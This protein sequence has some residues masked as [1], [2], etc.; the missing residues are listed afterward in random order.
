MTTEG[1]T[2][3]WVLKV[4]AALG[5]AT[6]L[7][8]AESAPDVEPT[9]PLSP[10]AS[11]VEPE[12][13]AVA[14]VPRPLEVPP[15]RSGSAMVRTPDSRALLIADEDHRVLRRV[16]LPLDAHAEVLTVALPGAPAS[17]LSLGRL[18][19]V[20]VRDPGLLLI[21]REE[22]NGLVEEA[23]I[24]LSADAWGL[25]VTADLKTALVT[26]AWTHQ[27]S[28]I[29]LEQR[30]LR[31]SVNVAREPRGIAI[32]N[33]G[34]AYVSHLVGSRLT[35]VDGLT[36]A[37]P[38]IKRVELPAA[39]MRAAYG[40]ALHASLGYA[41]VLNADESR[42]FAA[43]HAL[44]G[45]SS[46]WW[47]GAATVDAL[48]TAND[49][50]VSPAHQ[51][52]SLGNSTDMQSLLDIQGSVPLD[53]SAFVQPRAMAFRKTTNTILVVSEGKNELVELDARAVDPSLARTNLYPLASYEPSN[54]P[55]T[56]LPLTGGAP[57]A[58]ALSADEQ[59]A[60]V[61]GR[62]TN[63]VQ[64]F[65]L[66]LPRDHEPEKKKAPQP[67]VLLAEGAL[68]PEAELGR[69]LFYDA[70]DEIMSGG[71]GCAGCHPE[72]RDDGHV[73]HELS[74]A[75][76]TFANGYRGATVL[77]SVVA[78]MSGSPGGARAYLGKARQT[79]ML[80]GRVNARGPYGWLGESPDLESRVRVGFAL[81]R[82]QGSAEAQY[83]VGLNRPAQLARFLR[84]GLV[85]PPVDA[86]ESTASEQRG[87]AVFEQEKTG[88]AVCHAPAS[89]F[90]DRS[91]A[92][93]NRPNH[94][95]FDAET[96]PFKTPSLLFVGGTPPYFHDGAATTLEALVVRNG[97]Q[98]GN[99]AHL[100]AAD[101]QALA[102][103]LRTLGG[104]VAPFPEEPPPVAPKVHAGDVNGLPRRPD[105]A[106]WKGIKDPP[107]PGAGN[108]SL[109][110]SGPWFHVTCP[111]Q[112]DGIQLLAGTV[113]GTETWF[114]GRE[115]FVG[116]TGH[117]VFPLREG[118]R[119]V[120]QLTTPITVGKWGTSSDTLWFVQADWPVGASEPTILFTNP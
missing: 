27:L 31:W 79:P 36:A 59:T 89:D 119:K 100:N 65:S 64:A 45:Q 46:G 118:D 102:D 84:E 95:G 108:C 4:A 73:W 82:W 111:K 74:D 1:F 28:A 113:A 105:H 48:F 29:D 69:K 61:F 6:A 8:C 83:V 15:T 10:S 30:K 81:H 12:P 117:L 103:Y 5:V 38:T 112:L 101:Q 93:L 39:P 114:G 33:A 20:T 96:A 77:S 66:R 80:A 23:R 90:S 104:Y 50:P 42:L 52:N 54:A 107:Y 26:S 35:R 56:S 43:R 109:R 14:P 49:E 106:F 97:A 11:K 99:T 88:C 86:H 75:D 76:I 71:L 13:S 110:R 32:T 44:G 57:T 78:G 63:D 94:Q 60:Y 67:R 21:L 34:V 53:Q 68:K 22:E 25:A 18:V 87:K 19:L 41:A 92:V 120:F 58:I 24:P 115:D 16:G 116:G 91:L 40:T 17:V 70:T 85:A 9:A 7:G 37:T 3:R 51:P 72:G 55:F 2:G 62:S 47:F 98:M